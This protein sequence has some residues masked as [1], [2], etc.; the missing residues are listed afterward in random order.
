MKRRWT[1][2]VIIL[3]FFF[4]T[5][6][7]FSIEALPLLSVE[8]SSADDED[9]DH[10]VAWTESSHGR[11][12]LL[13]REDYLHERCKELGRNQTLEDLKSPKDFHNII[14][15]EQH[16]LLYCYVPKVLHQGILK[17]FKNNLSNR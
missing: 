10:K 6:G 1:V 5:N 17:F 8:N 3:D 9:S 15:D 13:D 11:S 12:N 14:V 16:E 2:F 4:T 7:E